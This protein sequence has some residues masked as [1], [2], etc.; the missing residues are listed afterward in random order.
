MKTTPGSNDS[1]RDNPPSS[2]GKPAEENSVAFSLT[3]L[4]AQNEQ[5]P[6][7]VVGMKNKD[8]SGLIDLNALIAMEDG[9]RK[10]PSAPVVPA[11]SAHIG[12]FPFEAQQAAAQQ[13]QYAAAPFPPDV[14]P[15]KSSRAWLWIGVAGV[16]AAAVGAFYIGMNA[17]GSEPAKTALASETSPAAAP[18]TLEASKPVE[19][20]KIAAADPGAPKAKDVKDVPAKDTAKPAVAAAP[21]TPKPA[22]PKPA[23]P[24]GD[25]ASEAPKKPAGGG[26]PCHGDLMCA[27]Q[28]ATKK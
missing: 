8:D 10:E 24:K 12:L 9:V 21:A 26:D 25:G 27:M 11:V 20:P 1:T 28:R 7:P 23:A 22:T 4:M 14:A 13:P 3:A 19:E 16:V 17:G 18:A 5:A 15:R 2:S 6:K